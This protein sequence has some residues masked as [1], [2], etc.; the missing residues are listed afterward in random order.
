MSSDRLSGRPA[1]CELLEATT[2]AGMIAATIAATIA[3]C[4]QRVRIVVDASSH[5]HGA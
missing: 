2:V 3:S 5:S 4:I 1:V